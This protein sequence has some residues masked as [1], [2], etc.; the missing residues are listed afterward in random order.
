MFDGTRLNDLFARLRADVDVL[1]DLGHV[2]APDATAFIATLPQG[3]SAAAPA[4]APALPPAA[5]RPMLRARAIWAYNE[6]GAEP[7]LSFAPGD[8][9]EVLERTNGDWWTGRV[10]GRQGAHALPARALHS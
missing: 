5:T 4:A 7:D 6:K 10:N 2:R 9:I 8:T 3:A 1:V